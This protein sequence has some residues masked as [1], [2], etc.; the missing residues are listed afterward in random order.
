MTGKEW[1]LKKGGIFQL[2]GRMVYNGGLKY[3]PG[4]EAQS[5]LL[6]EFVPQ[7]GAAFTE[8]VGAYFRIDTRIAYRKNLPKSA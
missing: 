1:E 8:N 7:E 6:G 3:T 2:G 4:D 5:K